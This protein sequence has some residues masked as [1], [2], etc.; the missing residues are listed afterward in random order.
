[1]CNYSISLDDSLV[2]QAEN[3]FQINDT[4]Q[5]WLQRQIETWLLS[6]IKSASV[7]VPFRH[8]SLSDELLAEKLKDFPPLSPADFPEPSP[9]EYANFLKTRSGKLPKG[10]EKWL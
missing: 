3:V 2:S 6:Q 10:C 4:F 5:D 7:K 8:G 9:S 1:M